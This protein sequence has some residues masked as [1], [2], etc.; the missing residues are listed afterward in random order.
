MF[1]YAIDKSEKAALAIKRVEI[2]INF[3]TYHVYQYINRGL[4]EKDK[5]TYV[6]MICF[7][8]A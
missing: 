3:L 5:V 4:F 7:K 1:D 8:I 2:I 6:L